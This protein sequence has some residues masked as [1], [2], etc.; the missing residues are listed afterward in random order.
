MVK[1]CVEITSGTG[2]AQ[3]RFQNRGDRVS[4]GLECVTPKKQRK[5]ERNGENARLIQGPQ[6]YVTKTCGAI[7]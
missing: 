5:N 2:Y 1:H 3:Q 4:K 6:N 7:Q